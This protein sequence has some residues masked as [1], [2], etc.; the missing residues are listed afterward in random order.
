MT[1]ES[2]LS[3]EEIAAL[4]NG[5]RDQEGTASAAPGTVRPFA[6]GGEVRRSVSAL[7][8]LDR[9]NER[10]AKRLRELIEPFTRTKL[11]VTAEAT[12]VRAFEEWQAE[13]PDFT[14]LSLYSFKPLKGGIL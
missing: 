14:S 5:L 11:R 3:G 4:M 6:F 13:Q 12:S 10:M 8:A 1:K 7:P 9:I 2:T